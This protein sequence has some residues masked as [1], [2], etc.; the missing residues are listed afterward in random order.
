MRKSLVIIIGAIV[1]AAVSLTVARTRHFDRVA[2]QAAQPYATPRNYIQHTD[3]DFEAEIS[4]LPSF[5]PVS[6]RAPTTAPTKPVGEAWA[7]PVGTRIVLKDDAD[8]RVVLALRK[9]P[10]DVAG[11]PEPGIARRVMGELEGE[12]GMRTTAEVGERRLGEGMGLQFSYSA[13]SH[14][15]TATVGVRG[16]RV[17]V[18]LCTGPY[19]E[20][21]RSAQR[22]FE[23]TLESVKLK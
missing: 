14:E 8:R 7:L 12:V 22:T 16:E 10:A 17:I 15:G 1:I 19:K 2:R 11:K 5:L 13:G 3:W 9:V 4:A 18:V 6:F 21:V 20:E 23:R